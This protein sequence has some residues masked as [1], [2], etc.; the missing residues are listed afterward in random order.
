[1]AQESRAVDIVLHGDISG[2]PFCRTIAE[3][4]PTAGRQIIFLSGYNC[5]E[6]GT[7]IGTGPD[8]DELEYKMEGEPEHFSYRTSRKYASFID[9]ASF[10]VP[11]WAPPVSIE[12]AHEV[13]W[14]LVNAFVAADSRQAGRPLEDALKGLIMAV[15]ARRLPLTA[16]QVWPMLSAHGW[17]EGTRVAMLARYSFGLNLLRDATGRQAVKRKAM[18]PF[19]SPRYVPASRR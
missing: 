13:H 18:P 15:W 6:V 12:D 11:D 9:L 17:P 7:V 5:G 8:Q 1:M 10:S 16:D 3:Q 4:L 19:G 14:G 2:C